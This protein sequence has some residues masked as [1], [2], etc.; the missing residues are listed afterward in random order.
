MLSKQ[1]DEPPFVIGVDVGVYFVENVE[2]RRI[3]SLQGKDEGEGKKRLLT[4]R[5]RRDR[6]HGHGT[7]VECGW[8]MVNK[9]A[10]RH[11]MVCG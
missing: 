9:V 10:Q 1:I 5:E 4:A 2:R 11:Q 8:I 6:L 7:V 3:D